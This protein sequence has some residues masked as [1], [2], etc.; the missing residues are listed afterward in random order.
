MGRPLSVEARAVHRVIAQPATSRQVAARLKMSMRD[1]TVHLSRMARRDEPLAEIV[2]HRKE[3]G[4][5]RPVPV[6]KAVD[7]SQI[8]PCSIFEALNKLL[9]AKRSMAGTVEDI[10]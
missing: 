1:A 3:P 6:Y 7:M 10:G 2:E 5:Q 8:E 4:V 9:I